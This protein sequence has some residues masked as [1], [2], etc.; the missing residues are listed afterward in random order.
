MKFR[1]R[2]NRVV[3]RGETRRGAAAVEFALVC[4]LL[5]MLLMGT[6]DLGQSVLENDHRRSLPVNF[7]VRRQG[8]PLLEVLP[9]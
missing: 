9:P 6:I 7:A 8:H 3:R 2:T 5:F 1:N 4:P